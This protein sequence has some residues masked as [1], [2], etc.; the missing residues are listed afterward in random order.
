MTSV[1]EYVLGV[2]NDTDSVVEDARLALLEATADPSTKRRLAT[3]GVVPGWRVAD[4]GAGRGSIAHHLA[5]L[6]GPRGRVVAADIDPRFLTGL[7]ANVEVRCMD[8]RSEDLEPWAYDLVH[9]RFVLD[10]MP[11]PLGLLHERVTAVRPL[12]RRSGS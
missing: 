11:D 1:S 6:V 9:C 12:V 3:L 5:E 4:V 8:I 2:H 7:P 10:H